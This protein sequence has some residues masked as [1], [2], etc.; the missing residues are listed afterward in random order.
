VISRILVGLLAGTIGGFLG[1]LLQE[2]LINYNAHVVPGVLPGQGAI[3]TGLTIGEARIL[4]LCVG[5]CIGLFLGAVD[6]IVEGSRRKLIRGIAIGVVAGFFLGYIGLFMGQWI[7][8]RLGGT[9]EGVPNPGIFSFGQQVI[10]RAF[11][12][13]LMGLGLGAGSAIST[14]SPKRIGQG[15]LGGFLGGFVGGFIFDLL[16]MGSAP[17]QEA[18]GA[19]GVHDSGGP[20]RMVG[21]TAIGGFTGLFI[22]LV[23]E[24]MKQ[25]WVKVLAGRNEGKDFIL[26]KPLNILGRDERSDVPLYGD[27]SVGIQHAAIRAD[28]NRHVLIDAHT[29]TGTV[30][31]GQP[32]PPGGELLLRD[33]DMIQIGS[34]RI[35]FREK[36]TASKIARPAVDTPRSKAG[37][38]AGVVPMPAHLCPF[39]GAPK[40]ASGNCLC[41]VGGSPIGAAG[42]PPPGYGGYPTPGAGSSAG[43]QGMSG[44]GPGTPA[45]PGAPMVG[46]V[47]IVPR[48][49]PDMPRLVGIEGPY[50]GEVFLLTSQNMTV[51]REPGRDIVLSADT[52]VSRNHARITNEGGDLVIYDNGSSNGTYVNGMRISMQ[53]LVPGDVVKF[54][55]SVFRFE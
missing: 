9:S 6:G 21:F 33:G 42:A 8:Q 37:S 44:Y 12:W 7:F 52:T 22:G 50:T 53:V 20:S 4:A 43:M 45:P 39:C 51:G 18:V 24:L 48:G 10:A 28:G 2:N 35:L 38:P 11:G 54:G 27:P 26:S 16:A 47:G 17:V 31:N 3:N 15:A 19:G 13:A 46:G 30:V 32:V 5:G 23:Q 29:P 49:G 34:H 41:T 36:A 40:D 14:W 1:W 55:S 25:A